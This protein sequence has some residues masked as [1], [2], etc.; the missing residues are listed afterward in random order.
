M[1]ADSGNSPLIISQ[2]QNSTPQSKI[3]KSELNNNNNL[4]VNL[5]S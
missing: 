5:A 2:I 4:A 1:L 3:E